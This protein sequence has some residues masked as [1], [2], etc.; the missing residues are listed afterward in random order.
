MFIVALKMLT[1]DRA[2]YI[3]LILGVAFSSLLIVQQ[4]SIFA[5]VIRLS[6]Y[7]VQSN[8]EVDIWVMRPGVEGATFIDQLPEIRLSQVR[9]VAGVQWA[10]P[11]YQSATTVRTVDEKHST[12]TQLEV[13][14]IDDSS[15][16]GR[17]RE[18]LLGTVEN[19][20]Q[21]NAVIL[22]IA[23]FKKLF[24]SL[25]PQT[26]VEIEIGHKRVIVVG[27]CRAPR[28]ITGGDILYARR[29]VALQLTQEVNNTISFIL[30]HI[31]PGEDKNVIADRIS[32]QTKLYAQTDASFTRSIAKWVLD[33]TGVAEV[34][35]AVIVLGVVVGILV[36]GQTFYM[37]ANDNRLHFAALKAMGAGNFM[38]YKMLA[39]QGVLVSFVGFGMGLGVATFILR[40]MDRDLSPMRGIT[41]SPAVAVVTAIALPI[42]VL[43][44]VIISARKVLQ[45][46]PS[47]VFR[48]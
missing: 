6:S 9:G 25:E 33:N 39:V 2:K 32:N 47:I 41:L 28:T 29:S 37:F 3:S 26:G 35:G 15:L 12:Y 42:I 46:D 1:G 16:I 36:V 10:A 30:V 31:N 44:T 27:I 20:R 7:L 17:P 43:I 40:S 14:G 18:M 13:R 45:Q 5:S 24:P 34:L 21:N 4:A 11:F 8:P 48:A 22:D 23:A 38:I 19:L